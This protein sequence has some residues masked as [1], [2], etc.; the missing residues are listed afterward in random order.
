MT[1]T[2]SQEPLLG[3]VHVPSKTFMKGPPF[4]HTTSSLGK[5]LSERI[6]IG[7]RPSMASS[8]GKF[9]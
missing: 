6:T 8:S 4:T 1:A 5:N 7:P 3:N 9:L 2:I